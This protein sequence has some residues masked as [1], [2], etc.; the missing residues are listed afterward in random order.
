MF[1]PLLGRVPPGHLWYLLRRMR[2]ERPHRFAG[3][4]RINT[5]FP[6]CPS[7]AFDRFCRAVID[8][9]RVPFSTYLAVTSR[10]PF[11]C[12]HCSLAGRRQAEWT[13]E[14]ALDLIAQ[15]KA[16]GTCTIGFTGGEPLLRDD[17][18]ELVAAAG[19][20][21]ATIVFTTGLGLDDRRAEALA[22]AGVTCVT[23]GIESDDPAR[24]AA[25]RGEGS[26]I[27][28]LRL[29]IGTERSGGSSQI[30]NRK[31]R[32]DNSWHAA[33]RAVESCRRAG[34]YAAISTIAARDK[35]LGGELERMH[36]LGRQWGVGEF[37][38]LA[39][40]ATGGWADRGQEMLSDDEMRAL[41]DFHVRTNRSGRLPAVA[42]FAYLESAELFGCGAGYHHL[43][44]D[45]AGEVCPCD[46]TPLSMGNALARPLAEIW[47]QMGE[48]FDRPRRG[49][50]MRELAGRITGPLPMPP[51]QSRRLCD[52]CRDRTAQ[53]PEGYRR[54]L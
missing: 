38:V 44:I 11:R 46:L 48:L 51:E 16:L 9:R 24:H 18:E 42:C 40:V 2:N 52:G 54:L 26:A 35:L 8:R 36:E 12:A 30:E 25:V 50:L 22:R 15:I 41:A 34:V 39:P 3:Q 5:F 32:I 7:P 53:L 4:T 17:L 28:D 33:R 13:R 23:V 19:P 47:A 1:R 31:S 21:M 37:R 29:S 6:P 20:E 10:C 49:C 14:Q 27:D 43:F 45:A